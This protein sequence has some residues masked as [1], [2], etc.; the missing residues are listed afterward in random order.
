MAKGDVTTLYDGCAWTYEVEGD[1][2]LGHSFAEREPA[3][4]GGRFLAQQ[5]GSVH[6]IREQDGTIAEVNRYARELVLT[7]FELKRTRA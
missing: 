2:P 6:T 3:I 5:R 4:A 1:E 7:T